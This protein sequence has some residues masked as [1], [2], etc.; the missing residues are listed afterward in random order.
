M[1]DEGGGGDKTPADTGGT[2][3]GEAFGERVEATS[4]GFRMVEAITAQFFPQKQ[5]VL[6]TKL[7]QHHHYFP[8]SPPLK[9][10]IFS[11][12]MTIITFQ[13]RYQ[14]SDF[15]S[16]LPQAIHKFL[17]QKKKKQTNEDPIPKKHLGIQQKSHYPQ[18]TFNKA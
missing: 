3:E 7:F 9:F 15:R 5:N 10:P 18:T 13:I 14:T 1:E 8:K 12:N 11:Q 17:H 4:G 6:A 16:T 2:A